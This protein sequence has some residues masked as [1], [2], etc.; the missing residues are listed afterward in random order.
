MKKRLLSGIKPTGDI[1]IGN[2][3]GAMRQF[4]DLQND[5]DSYIFIADYH[6]LNQI[7]DPLTLSRN[8][9]ETAKAYLAVGLDSQR[10]VL[11][12]QSDVPQ[13]TEL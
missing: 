2:Y 8:I 4:V 1:H 5:Y 13:V 9:L 11:F 10:V 3:F 12:K 7:Q 6:A